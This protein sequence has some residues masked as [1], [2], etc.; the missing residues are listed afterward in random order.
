MKTAA[1]LEKDY[2]NNAA[3]KTL[4]GDALLTAG[5]A[6]QADATYAQAFELTPWSALFLKRYAALGRAK[7]PKTARKPLNDWLE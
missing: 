2:P 6:K 5:K 4:L 3:V 1:A 7:P